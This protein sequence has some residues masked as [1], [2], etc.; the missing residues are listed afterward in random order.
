MTVFCST[1]QA[2]GIM[3]FF[4][5]PKGTV[6]N[7][8]IN[9]GNGYSAFVQTPDLKNGG[10]KNGQVHSLTIQHL[11]A[12]Q[13]FINFTDN[14]IVDSNKS[15]FVCVGAKEQPQE[16]ISRIQTVI[17]EGEFIY[18]HRTV[19]QTKSC[20][21]NEKNVEMVGIR[22]DHYKHRTD[23][24]SFGLYVADVLEKL[25]DSLMVNRCQCWTENSHHDGYVDEYDS[26]AH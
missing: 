11:G 26:C 6:Y 5:P 7:R 15:I 4:T 20:Y 16:C 8:P 23:L 24:S 25:Q 10:R 1:V 13:L 9:L 12:L 21:K 18:K 19:V 3:S 14:L 2:Q 17:D 22:I